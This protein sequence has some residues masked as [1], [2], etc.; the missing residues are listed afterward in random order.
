MQMKIAVAITFR[1][2][3]K[4]P[5]IRRSTRTSFDQVETVEDTEKEEK[6]QML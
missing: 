1:A 3:F 2:L 6:I 4:I 5:P